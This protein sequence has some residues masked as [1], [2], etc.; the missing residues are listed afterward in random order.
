MFVL[1][2]VLSGIGSLN[3]T[4]PG[5]SGKS[6]RLYRSL[7]ETRLAVEASVSFG[8]SID[9]DLLVIGAAALSNV[10]PRRIESVILKELDKLASEPPTAEEMATIRKQVR[11]QVVYSDD[12]VANL[13]F[14]LGT[15]EMASSYKDYLDILENVN[16]VTAEDVQR[17]AKTYLTEMN[18][19]VGWFIPSPDEGGQHG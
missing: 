1:A 7:V 15:F 13:G 2:G 5:A 6:A 17:V 9:P 16:R 18:R 10:A 12:G 4:S 19:T 3:F 8:A 14:T 11:T